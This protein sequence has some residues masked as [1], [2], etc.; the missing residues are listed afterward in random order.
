M[1]EISFKCPD[2]HSDLV[3]SSSVEI[4]EID[5]LNGT[6][7]TSCGRV[8]SEDDIL[9]QASDYAEKIFM[10]IFKK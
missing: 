8:I 10:D 5:D 4:K 3:V 2:C 7:C 6:T 1:S 9:G